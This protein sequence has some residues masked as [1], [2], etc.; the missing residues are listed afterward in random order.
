MQLIIQ[1]KIFQKSAFKIFKYN[2]INKFLIPDLTFVCLFL[3][4]DSVSVPGLNT[5]RIIDIL[6]N[7]EMMAKIFP[8]DNHS[9]VRVEM[10]KF[11]GGAEVNIIDNIVAELKKIKNG[12]Y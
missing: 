7:N 2:D 4:K 12:G 6:N 1:I 9:N 8:L 11:L 10:L 3:G 5:E